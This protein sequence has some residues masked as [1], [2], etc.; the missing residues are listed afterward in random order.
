M[1]NY[2]IAMQLVIIILFLISIMLIIFKE[3]MLMFC[4]LIQL[5]VGYRI[6]SMD[7]N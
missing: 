2:R 5:Y 6:K 4:I 7:L 1:N 3:S